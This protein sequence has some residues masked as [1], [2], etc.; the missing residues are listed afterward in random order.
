[1]AYNDYGAFVYENGRRRTDRE[2]VPAFAE[3]DADLG[4]GGRIYAH[5]ARLLAE[6]AEGGVRGDE[7]PLDDGRLY[8]GVLGDGPV[9]VCLY[10]QGMW[11]IRIV[12][13]H[14][15]GQVERIDPDDVVR[16]CDPGYVPWHAD[17]TDEENDE[18]ERWM[19][20]PYLYETEVL[21]H[22][23]QFEA[24]DGGRER[25]PRFRARMDCPDGT[26]W[27][28]WYD[29]LYGAGHI[30]VGAA[31]HDYDRW[32]A[33]RDGVWGP[34][35]HTLTVREYDDGTPWAG[36]LAGRV[37]AVGERDLRVMARLLGIGEGQEGEADENALRI[38]YRSLFEAD[39][40]TAALMGL[41]VESTATARGKGADL[42][43]DV[44][45]EL[46]RIGIRLGK[47]GVDEVDRDYSSRD[48]PIA[49]DGRP[50]EMGDGSLLVRYGLDDT[51][52][53]GLSWHL[54]ACGMARNP[55]DKPDDASWDTWVGQRMSEYADRWEELANGNLDLVI[56]RNQVG[57]TASYPIRD[58][59]GEIIEPL[60]DCPGDEAPSW[61]LFRPVGSDEPPIEAVGV[62]WY[63]EQQVVLSVDGMFPA[64]EIELVDEDDE[65]ETEGVSK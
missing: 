17:M 21:G 48:W 39:P 52:F 3:G 23:I 4:A 59:H 27:E 5:I 34:Q 36:G 60:M 9:R 25:K 51:P 54:S 28:A 58:V 42:D 31:C 15:D 33:E 61:P 8:H 12:A 18:Y 44:A 55:F 26:R 14:E 30:D 43:L 49:D 16:R 29:A 41:E 7:S 63:D 50:G 65:G 13:V 45:L 22:R 64:A 32:D 11:G 20:G 2:D 56:D 46:V 57:T 47:M 53:E 24:R 62:G 38:L 10:K 37:Y 1:M 6:A 19:L 40:E 35:W